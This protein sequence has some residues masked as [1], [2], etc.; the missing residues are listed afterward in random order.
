MVSAPGGPEQNS[1]WVMSVGGRTGAGARRGRFGAD[2]FLLF[3]AESRGFPGMGKAGK[4]LRAAGAAEM[5][6]FAWHDGE[7][8]RLVLNFSSAL[9]INVAKV[10]PF[11]ERQALVLHEHRSVWP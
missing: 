1:A 10:K 3:S 2:E 8:H 6:G 5:D 4:R 9:L 7:G 11:L